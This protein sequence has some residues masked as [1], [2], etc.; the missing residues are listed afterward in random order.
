M[1]LEYVVWIALCIA[2]ALRRLAYL[3]CFAPNRYLDLYLI[4]SASLVVGRIP[5]AWAEMEALK[6][7]GLVKS[8]GVSNF[9]IEDL[10]ILRKSSKTLPAVNQILFTAYVYDETKDLLA[11]MDKHHIVAEAY[12]VLL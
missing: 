10:E 4:H 2:S 1:G 9:K 8:I 11:Y 7:Q 12:S 3:L 5:E 6:E